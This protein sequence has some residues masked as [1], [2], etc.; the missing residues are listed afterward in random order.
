MSIYTNSL[1]VIIFLIVSIFFIAC[2][3]ID[4]SS[5][6]YYKIKECTIPIYSSFKLYNKN[7]RINEYYFAS[8]HFGLMSSIGIGSFKNSYYKKYLKKLQQ[9]DYPLKLLSDKKQGIFKVLQL[10]L[11]DDNSSNHYMLLGKKSKIQLL[12]VDK[13]YVDYLIDHCTKTYE[14]I[15]TK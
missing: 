2:K 4:N 13:E 14:D 6:N 10:K 15:N 7:E 5:F 8:P 1:K 9:E 12:N 11:I 3:D